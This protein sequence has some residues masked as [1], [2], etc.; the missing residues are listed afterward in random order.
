L[1]AAKLDAPAD[2]AQLVELFT[3][4]DAG[5]GLFRPDSAF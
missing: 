2:V 5:S 3:G 1:T 4:N